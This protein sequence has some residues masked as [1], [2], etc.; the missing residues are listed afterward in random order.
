MP[1]NT[2]LSPQQ[3]RAKIPHTWPLFFTR[4]GRFTPIQQQAIPPI[5]AGSD[6]LAI[7]PTASGKTEA[8]IAPLLERYWHTLQKPG[9]TLLYICPTRALV[10]DLYERLTP[11]LQDSGLTLGMKTGDVSLPVTIPAILITTPESTD[12]M[13]VRNPKLF[14]HLQAVV[15]DEIHLFDQTARG[16]QLRCL[17]PRIETIREYARAAAQPL[18]RVALSATVSDPEGIAFRYLNKATILSVPSTRQIVVDVR[19]LPDLADLLDALV[20]RNQKKSLIF[21]N[22]RVEVEETAVYLRNH[23]PYQA[24]IFVHYSNLDAAVRREI[25]DRF[26]QATVAIC[27]STSTLEL[28]IDIGTVDDVILIGAPFNQTSFLQRIGR[29]GRRTMVTNTLCLPK[30]PIEAARFEAM[31]ALANDDQLVTPLNPPQDSFR[32]SVLVQQ[33]FSLLKQSPTGSVRLADLRRLAPPSVTKQHLEKLVTN[34]TFDGYLKSGRIGEWQP[35][36]KLYPLLDYHEIYSNIGADVLGAVAVD[37]LTG[38]TIAQTEKVYPKGLIVLF[39]GQSMRVVW[40]E[41]YRFGVAPAPNEEPDAVLRFQKSL[42]VVPFDVAQGVARLLGLG[43]HQMAVLPQEPGLFLF[44]FWGTVWGHLLSSVLEATGIQTKQSNEF[45]FYIHQQIQQLPVLEEQL[46]DKVAWETAV[47]LSRRLEMGR[48]HKLL[49]PD[50]AAEATIHLLNLAQ[51]KLKY[52]TAKIQNNP[53][54]HPALHSLI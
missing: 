42:P 19:P 53:K 32:P 16:D 9:L 7:A 4:Y 46:V 13:I 28:G 11:V 50:M 20:E 21:C 43:P 47:S 27:V 54:I 5:L 12:A 1:K 18:Q 10:R 6:A 29:G 41:P 26:A 48:F 34:L 33:L 31:L 8:V 49:P 52:K 39:G 2:F 17:L 14:I 25:E 40:Q 30:S 45:G 35:A 37:A 23:L 44:H 38:R 24:D 36:E 15:L 3:V 22:T 51:F